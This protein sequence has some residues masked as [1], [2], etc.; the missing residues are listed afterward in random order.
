MTDAEWNKEAEKVLLNRKIVAVRYM[1]KAEAKK[2]GW[3]KRPVC[4]TLDNG[5]SLMVSMDDEGNDG[6]SLFFG[7]DGTLPT[8]S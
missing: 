1:T 7:K 6:G 3:Y 4:F 2:M 5:E 8:L